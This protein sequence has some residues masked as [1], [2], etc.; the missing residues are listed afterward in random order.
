M[1][2]ERQIIQNFGQVR[3]GHQ[4]VTQILFERIEDLLSPVRL[5]ESQ[6]ANPGGKGGLHSPCTRWRNLVEPRQRRPAVVPL[7][8]QFR[9][10]KRRLRPVGFEPRRL[11]QVSQPRFIVVGEQSAD[12]LLERG[13]TRWML[14]LRKLSEAGRKPMVRGS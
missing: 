10:G 2:R 14:Q 4:V 3:P 11:L 8:I 1:S 6:A 12:V 9:N 13:Q 5:P 7:K